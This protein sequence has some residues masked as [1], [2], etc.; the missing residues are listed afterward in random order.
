MIDILYIELNCMSMNFYCLGSISKS[1]CHGVCRNCILRQHQKFWVPYESFE[2]K[3]RRYRL[4]LNRDLKCVRSIDT[5]LKSLFG[6]KS[7]RWSYVDRTWPFPCLSFT[8]TAKSLVYTRHLYLW[9]VTGVSYDQEL[10]RC[11]LLTAR[12]IS[13]AAAPVPSLCTT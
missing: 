1:L 12:G 5:A 10:S 6:T 11:V 8:T 7:K 13:S 4:L 2:W 3:V 9:T